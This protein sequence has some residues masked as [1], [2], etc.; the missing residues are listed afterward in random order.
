MKYSADKYPRISVIMATLNR[1]A[2][3][4]KAI[5]SL[6]EQNYPN[7]D[8]LVLDAG[9][10]DNTLAI[11][12]RYKQYITYF[13]SRADKGPSDA[14][15][16]GVD[17][18]TGEIICF[19]NSDD[20]YEPG[21]LIRV[22]EA[23][24]ENK[25]LDIVNVLGRMVALSDSGELVYGHVTTPES[26]YLKNGVVGA[27]HPNCRFYKKYLFDKYG[28]FISEIDGVMALASDYEFIT[29]LSLYNPKNITLDFIGYN[30][31]GHEGSL[32]YNNNKYTKLRLYDQKV[33]YVEQLLSKHSSVIG[34]GLRKKLWKEYRVA[35]TRRVV[36]LFVDKNFKKGFSSLAKGVRAFGI[37]FPFKV[38]RYFISYAFRFNK[39]FKKAY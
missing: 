17:M 33:Y 34:D 39:I 12:D 32:T 28:K 14:W 10:N 5:L 4:E 26:M 36:K 38:L 7:L 20:F 31:L 21:T 11:V 22:G 37:L 35:Y 8:F 23:L 2:T 9:S 6:I 13:R 1:Q 29:R 24:I 18:S 16:E 30:Y 27:L 19:L 25:D 15:N 3:V